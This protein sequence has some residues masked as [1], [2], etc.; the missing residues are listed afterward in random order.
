MVYL[1][2]CEVGT[3]YLDPGDLANRVPAGSQSFSCLGCGELVPR[4]RWA[5]PRV[6]RRFRVTWDELEASG[7][8]W[9]ASRK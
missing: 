3:V 9:A 4:G 6:D 7:W 1:L 5:G 2:K 8:A